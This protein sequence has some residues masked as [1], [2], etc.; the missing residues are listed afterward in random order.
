[1]QRPHP[2]VHRHHKNIDSN[3]EQQPLI[4][5]PAYTFKASVTWWKWVKLTAHEIHSVLNPRPPYVEVTTSSIPSDRY[6]EHGRHYRDDRPL[7]LFY[8]N[9]PIQFVQVVGVVVA[10]EDYFEK[11]WLFTI[12][13]SSGAT[14][15]VTCRKPEKETENNTRDGGKP[16]PGQ[17]EATLNPKADEEQRSL[18]PTEQ[19]ALRASMS[20]LQIGT[21]VQAKG[22]LSAFR[23]V[24]QLTLLRLNIV[25]DTTHEMALISSRTQFLKSTLSKPWVVTPEEQ[26]KLH[27]EAQGER[28]EE[29]KHAARRRKR[30]I[31]RRE[32]E[33]RH[34]RLI[35]EEYEKEEEERKRGAEEARSA[36]EAMYAAGT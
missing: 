3:L 29:N 19:Q 34:A 11:F 33:A 23:S 35:R 14:I 9:H 25:P 17:N 21:V 26:Q 20:A 1:M 6:D 31:K 28:D 27:W 36:G 16:R 13:D 8:L 12:D 15:D 5:Y 30:S 4:F 32:R 18:D 7:L 10:L 24:R 2:E 22:T